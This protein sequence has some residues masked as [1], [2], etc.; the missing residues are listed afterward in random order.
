VKPVEVDLKTDFVTILNLEL[1]KIVEGDN[2]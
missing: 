2:D 1:P